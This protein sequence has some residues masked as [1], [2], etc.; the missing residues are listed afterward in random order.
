[1]ARTVASGVVLAGA[2]AVLRRHPSRRRSGRVL[3]PRVTAAASLAVEPSAGVA[4]FTPRRCGPGMHA[5][6]GAFARRGPSPT[7]APRSRAARSP[8]RGTVRRSSVVSGPG[9]AVIRARSGSA[10]AQP[11]WIAPPLAVASH[12]VPDPAA[13]L[14]SARVPGTAFV[15]LLDDLAVLA[16]ADVVR[17][18]PPVISWWLPGFSSCC[19]LRCSCSPGAARRA[20]PTAR[21][22]FRFCR[23]AG[24]L[25]PPAV[26]E[27]CQ[28]V[29]R[30]VRAVCL[31]RVELN[32]GRVSS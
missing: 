9:L 6:R 11:P 18:A 21:P 31:P 8:G 12:A 4:F 30:A 20:G 27:R 29:R 24:V 10:V 22:A 23:A 7:A 13:R 25:A 2:R 14:H 3:L 28:R 26:P 5:G 17:A 32:R 19:Q 1:M 15:A 16:A